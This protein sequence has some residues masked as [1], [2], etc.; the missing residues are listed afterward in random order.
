MGTNFSNMNIKK[1]FDTLAEILSD[2]HDLRISIN[3]QK[4]N[5]NFKEENK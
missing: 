4:K 3:I 1:F 5:Y 2:K